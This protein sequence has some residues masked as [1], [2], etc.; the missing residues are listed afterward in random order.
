M[1]LAVP[2]M[3]SYA[4][5]K[6]LLAEPGATWRYSSGTSL[7]ISRVIRGLFASD[8]EYLTFPRR[9][10]FD[11]IGMTG[12]TLE[13]DAAGTLVASSF[14]YATARDWA[15]FGLLY[16]QDG[17]W[18]GRRILPEGW[19][20]Y[21]RTPAP[22]DPSRRYGAHFWL[23]LPAYSGAGALPADAYHAVG[24]EGQFV[25]IVP[26]RQLVVVRL[27]RTRYPDGWDHAAFV[28]DVLAA[29]GPQ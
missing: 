20:E 9:A 4:A 8:L 27:G 11:P 7:I 26:S 1:L 19:V 24:H 16:L 5:G 29:I 14:M 2:D 17:Q 18:N 15:R 21:S 22:A 12:A 10:L 23:H 6:R 25:T 3:A 28:R 13:A